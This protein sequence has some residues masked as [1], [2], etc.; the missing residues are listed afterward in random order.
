MNSAQNFLITI[1]G[2][3][4]EKDV[5]ERFTEQ[6]EY[7][8]FSIRDL[9]YL[10]FQ[11][12]LSLLMRLEVAESVD[13][14]TLTVVL[15]KVAKQYQLELLVF[16]LPQMSIA[17]PNHRY[18]L[19][20]LSRKLP[21]QLLTKLFR[22]LREKQLYVTEVSPLDA[23]ELHVFEIKIHADVPIERQQLM[24]ELLELKSEYQLDLALQDDDL[25]RRNKR[26]IFMDADMT[27]IQ[28]EMINDMSRLAGN[29]AEVT[30]ITQRAMD[31]ELKFDEALRMRVALLKGVRLSD[32]ERLILNI[33]Y[34][35]GV[36]R[37]VFILK[38]LGYKIGIV[39]GGFT[40]VIDHIKQRFNLDYGFANT[41]EVKNGELTGRILGDILDG[42]QKGVILR[43]VALKENILPEQVIAVGDGANDLEMLSSAS[44][45][46]AFNAKRYLSERA[47]GS[48]SLP[49]LD[50]LL[51]FLGISKTEIRGLFNP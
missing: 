20:L 47:A 50:A 22:H 32:L 4:T 42:H 11:S 51:Y 26:L 45:G 23:D 44:L 33:P 29:E 40:R 31:G 17:V 19:T 43:E 25:F 5:L 10:N 34:T 16:P 7:L 1:Q 8:N 9:H 35:P 46:V 37:L 2:A 15:E 24:K 6:L 3:T 36:E 28:C 30:K 27:F 49:N 13:K 21:P 38:T 18:I 14:E 12:S 41:L 48:L 39:S